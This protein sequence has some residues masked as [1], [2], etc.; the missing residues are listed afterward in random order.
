MEQHRLLLDFLLLD[1]DTSQIFLRVALDES[2]TGA[3]RSR[4]R[5]KARSGYDAVL[6]FSKRIE[7]APSEK[8]ELMARLRKLKRGLQQ[9]GERFDV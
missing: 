9:A 1:L 2:E 6:Y 8:R 5:S 4:N 3:T 7:I